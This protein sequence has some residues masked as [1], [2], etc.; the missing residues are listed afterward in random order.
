MAPRSLGVRECRP[1]QDGR[2]VIIAFVDT[3]IRSQ[4]RTLC[5]GIGMGTLDP[6]VAAREMWALA[7]RNAPRPDGSADD[8]AWAHWL[9][10]G[11]LTD[12]IEVRPAER[13]QA[14][15]AI[16]AAAR[17]W[18]AVEAV[19]EARLAFFDRMVYDVCGYQRRE[20]PPTDLDPTNA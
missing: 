19:P 2:R 1:K 4:L 8:E 11:A 13:T 3:A 18:L 20:G 6:Y 15:V 9:I 14:E 17:E 5:S 10:W 12:R 16:V 7:M